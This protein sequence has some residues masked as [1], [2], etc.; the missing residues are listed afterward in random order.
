MSDGYVT[1]IF[2]IFP[3]PHRM[4]FIFRNIFIFLSGTL[5]DNIYIYIYIYILIKNL[6]VFLRERERQ[7][8]RERGYVICYVSCY[9]SC[10]VIKG[11]TKFRTF[12]KNLRT[13]EILE[14]YF[15]G[16]STRYFPKNIFEK[17][18]LRIWE[19]RP[20]L[21]HEVRPS[22]RKYFETVRFSSVLSVFI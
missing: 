18:L 6:I 19:N 11:V 8:E 10:Y 13:S 1:K 2:G 14:K 12:Q 17:H 22:K 4:F 7:R 5:P 9:V 3:N 20:K 16:Y 21:G 15:I